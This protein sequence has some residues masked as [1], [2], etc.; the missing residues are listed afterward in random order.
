M[1]LLRL[2]NKNCDW[3]GFWPA[4]AY[5][6]AGIRMTGNLLLFSS[7]CSP[8]AIFWRLLKS[9]L[10]Q[11]GDRAFSSLMAGIWM[12]RDLSS[13]LLCL[14]VFL[15]FLF[16]F[17]FYLKVGLKTQK[18]G[19]SSYLEILSFLNFS[20]LQ[21]IWGC[22]TIIILLLQAS[23]I[24]NLILQ[25]HIFDVLLLSRQL[26]GVSTGSPFFHGKKLE[27]QFHRASRTLLRIH[28]QGH[29]QRCAGNKQRTW[30]QQPMTILCLLL[31]MN[32]PPPVLHHPLY[33]VLSKPAIVT[34]D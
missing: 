17:F 3:A 28:H 24:L 7:K 20:F 5:L 19:G 9:T 6:M 29:L 23:A 27:S 16:L 13:D 33:P 12:L 34:R 21:C 14:L 10:Y 32:S 1:S 31:L 8:S 25:Q 15:L 26:S 11:E 4:W 18:S 22:Y 30:R 2:K